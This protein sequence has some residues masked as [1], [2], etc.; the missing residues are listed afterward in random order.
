M[1]TAPLRLVHGGK[2]GVVRARRVARTHGAVP[3]DAAGPHRRRRPALRRPAGRGQDDA[4]RRRPSRRVAA[5]PRIYRAFPGGKDEVVDAVVETE[6]ARLFRRWPSRIA[7]ADDLEDVLV[8][9]MSGGAAA[10]V[11][12]TGRS[13]TS[14]RT[15]PGSCCR[16]RIRQDGHRPGVA[17]AI[18]RAVPRS[19]PRS[20]GRPPASASGRRASCLVYLAVPRRRSTVADDGLGAARSSGTCASRVRALFAAVDLRQSR[21]AVVTTRQVR[22]SQHDKGD[23]GSRRMV[24]TRGDHRPGRRERPRG[25]PLDRSTGRGQASTP[26]PP[27]TRPSSPGTTT[28]APGPSWTSS[29]R[30]RRSRCGTARP[31]CPGTPRSTRS[32]SSWPT[33]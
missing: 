27:T 7:G 28:R 23:P 14:S 15:S 5:G 30:R 18:R 10:A 1:A 24:S 13:A 11:Q 4:R 20:R 8:L 3:T 32:G 29:T 31:T 12:A 26:S 21:R 9:A 6:V 19:L 17:S 16:S 33:R 2:G 22:L 25:D